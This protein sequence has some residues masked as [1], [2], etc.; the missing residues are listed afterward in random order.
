VVLPAD[1]V[2]RTVLGVSRTVLGARVVAPGRAVLTV[3][4][5]SL[6]A[7]RSEGRVARP[8]VPFSAAPRVVVALGAPL[9]TV[10]RSVA[11][12]NTGRAARSESPE[13]RTV[14]LPA[15]VAGATTLVRRCAVRVTLPLGLSLYVA[16]ARARGDGL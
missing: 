1:G 11:G 8:A 16:P 14:V 4:A 13:A 10:G 2:P 5:R 3:P 15:A 7:A 6:P 9:L 12:L